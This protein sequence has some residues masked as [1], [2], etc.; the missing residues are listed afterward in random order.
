MVD[1]IPADYPRVMPYLIVEGA[2]AAIAFYTTVL[3]ATERMRMDGPGGTIVHAEIQIGDAVLMLADAMPDMGWRS[4][5]Q[6]GG[7]PVGLMV[8]VE[9]VDATFRTALDNGATE[10][11]APSDQFY[12]DRT[13]QFRD[14]FGH[15]WYAATHVEDVSE[16]EMGKRAAEAMG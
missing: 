11:R 7:T 14:P 2:D 16:E 15:E 1:P 5:A 4:P 10:M 8:Y 9:D 6:V 3:G 13:A 12:G